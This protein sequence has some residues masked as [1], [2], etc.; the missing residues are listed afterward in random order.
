MPR[1]ADGV[2]AEQPLRERATVVGAGG[3]D[4]K[5][6]IAAA[7]E[8]DRLAARMPEQGRVPGEIAFGDAGLQ[9]G[10]GQLRFLSTHAP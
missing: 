9:I 10:P 7:N 6:F 5:H 4:G 1:A 3:A 2:A 8:D